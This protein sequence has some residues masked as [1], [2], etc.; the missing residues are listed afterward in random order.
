MMYLKAGTRGGGRAIF[1][2]YG[3]DGTPYVMVDAIRVAAATVA[4]FAL[5]LTAVH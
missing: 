3:L 1:T 4:E 2:L 5:S